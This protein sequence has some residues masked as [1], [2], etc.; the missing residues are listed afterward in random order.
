[1][2]GRRL[3][4]T[5]DRGRWRRNE[6]Y[7]VKEDAAKVGRRNWTAVAINREGWRKL[8][9][10]TEAHRRLQCLSDGWKESTKHTNAMCG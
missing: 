1:M 9:K 7:G 4:R 3:G 5:W 8:L 10:K 2:E 6:F